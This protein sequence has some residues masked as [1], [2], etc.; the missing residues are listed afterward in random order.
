MEDIVE[1]LAGLTRRS[2]SCVRVGRLWDARVL[3][4]TLVLR[5]DAILPLDHWFNCVPLCRAT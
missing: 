1:R 3:E 4:Q 2:S 5:T